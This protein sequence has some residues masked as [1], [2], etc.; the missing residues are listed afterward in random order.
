MIQKVYIKKKR[1]ETNET[2]NDSLSIRCGNTSLIG[3][4]TDECIEFESND[5]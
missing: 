4:D 2:K 1:N 5:R 3:W